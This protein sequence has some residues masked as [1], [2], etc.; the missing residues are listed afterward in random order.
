MATLKT[1]E[2]GEVRRLVKWKTNSLRGKHHVWRKK[3]V[4]VPAKEVKAIKQVPATGPVV[5]KVAPKT[6]KKSA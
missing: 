5:A 1:M 3:W 2:N 4:I 6:M